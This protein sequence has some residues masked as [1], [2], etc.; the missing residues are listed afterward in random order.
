M[1]DLEKGRSAQELFDYIVTHLAAQGGPST[2]VIGARYPKNSLMG[3][4]R[5]GGGRACSIGCLLTDEE[6]QSLPE[7][8]ALS[9]LQGKE[10]VWLDGTTAD[11]LTSIQTAHDSCI[12]ERDVLPEVAVR[13]VRGLLVSLAKRLGLN[14]SRVKEIERWELFIP[15]VK[16]VTYGEDADESASVRQRD[17]ASS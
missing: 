2:L 15:V 10:L 3:A 17:A 6:V 8:V 1:I 9:C 12:F 16:G 7:G 5:G 14:W 11:L 13:R 4:Y